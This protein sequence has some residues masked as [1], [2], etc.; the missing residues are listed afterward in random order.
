MESVAVTS[1]SVCLS[2]STKVK[3]KTVLRDKKLECSLP[4]FSVVSILF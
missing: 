1:S 3:E 4:I 2:N